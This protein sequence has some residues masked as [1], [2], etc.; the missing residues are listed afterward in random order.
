M[1]QRCLGTYMWHSTVA[2]VACHARTGH[3][4]VWQGPCGACGPCTSAQ[5]TRYKVQGTGPKNGRLFAH[6][7]CHTY[8]R[9]PVDARARTHARTPMRAPTF[10]HAP[11]HP[12]THVHTHAQSRLHGRPHEQTQLIF[13]KQ[14]MK[15]LN[16]SHTLIVN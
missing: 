7:A 14:L 13:V 1:G 3:M 4:R 5:G 9:A 2:Q 12:H 8:L 10:I 6:A 16:D 15:R 11:T